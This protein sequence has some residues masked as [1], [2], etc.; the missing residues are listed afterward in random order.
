MTRQETS[1]Q[2]SREVA[3]TDSQY[4]LTSHR[5]PFPTIFPSLR[6][7]ENLNEPSRFCATQIS[8]RSAFNPPPFSSI[9]KR[10]SPLHAENS[11]GPVV[12]LVPLIHAPRLI[13]LIRPFIALRDEPY[14]RGI[15]VAKTDRVS[16]RRSQRRCRKPPPRLRF[17]QPSWIVCSI[18]VTERL[19][20]GGKDREQPC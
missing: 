12:L 14:G 19:V 11:H 6:L 17:Y 18:G 2:W 20:T 16:R 10:P 13:L 1:T 3:A 9:Q 8:F 15:S 7:I 4:E 5:H